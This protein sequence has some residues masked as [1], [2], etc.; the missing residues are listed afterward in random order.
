M[1]VPSTCKHTSCNTSFFSPLFAAL[2]FNLALLIRFLDT[3]TYS[4]FYMFVC[5][6]VGVCV[7]VCVYVG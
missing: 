5:V 6:Y 3:Y 2:V 7:C 1:L 4:F